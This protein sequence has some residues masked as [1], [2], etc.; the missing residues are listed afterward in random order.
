MP[1]Y[2]TSGPDGAE[3]IVVC[4]PAFTPDTVYRDN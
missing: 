4:L 1:G 2:S 3:Y